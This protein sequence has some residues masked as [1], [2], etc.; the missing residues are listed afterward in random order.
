[1]LWVSCVPRHPKH[2]NFF[3]LGVLGAPT[4]KT[5]KPPAPYILLS[6]SSVVQHWMFGAHLDK[7]G[8]GMHYQL[9]TKISSSWNIAAAQK[10]TDCLADDFKRYF[11]QCDPSLLGSSSRVTQVKDGDGDKHAGYS[12]HADDNPWKVRQHGSFT[13][14]APGEYYKAFLKWQDHVHHNQPD[15]MELAAR[16]IEDWSL[17]ELDA[18]YNSSGTALEVDAYKFRAVAITVACN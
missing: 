11:L 14:K 8:R 3:F 4:P 10:W 13:R 9:V 5:P 7:S 1:M 18:F 17:Y 6:V 15:E 16:D 12:C 2:P